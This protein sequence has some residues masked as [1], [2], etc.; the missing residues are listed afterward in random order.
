MTQ[1]KAQESLEGAGSGSEVPPTQRVPEEIPP[2]QRIETRVVPTNQLRSGTASQ[3]VSFSEGELKTFRGYEVK[4]PLG[5]GGGESRT[6]LVEKEG[7]SYL[8]K[9]Y[10]PKARPDREVFRRLREEEGPAARYFPKIYEHGEEVVGRERR[11]FEIAEYLSE[12]SLREFCQTLPR[13]IEKRASVLREIVQQ[14]AEALHALHKRDIIHRDLKPSNILLRSRAPLELVL[15]DFGIARTLRDQATKHQTTRFKGTLAYC[16]PEEFSGLFGKGVDWWHLGIIAYEVLL[17]RNPF[18]GAS[19]PVINNQITTKD[20]P[21]PAEIQGRER[22]L[23]LGL[24]TRDPEK[25]WGYKEVMDWL[26]GESP[27]I[28][29]PDKESPTSSAASKTR[30]YTERDWLAAGFTQESHKHWEK[31]GL[32]PREAQSFKEA[33]YSAPTAAK[34]VQA[35]FKNGKT[36]RSWERANFSPEEAS[37]YESFGLSAPDAQQ[38]RQAGFT[39]ELLAAHR[40]DAELIQRLFEMIR[41]NITRRL[42]LK[43]LLIAAEEGLSLQEVENLCRQGLTVEEYVALRKYGF[44]V[45]DQNYFLQG[46]DLELS[47]PL[48]LSRPLVM[49]GGKLVLPRLIA[50][51]LTLTQGAHLQVSAMQVGKKGLTLEGKS[52]LAFEEAE[53]NG[54]L[55]LQESHL[56]GKRL[57]VTGDLTAQQAKVEV[58]ELNA[59]AVTFHNGAELKAEKAQI[60]GP[61]NLQESQLSVKNATIRAPVTA[62]K[63]KITLENIE[64]QGA[65]V[66]GP[67]RLQESHLAGKRLIVTGDLTAQQAKVEV[68][69]LNAQAVTFHNGAELKA[70]KAQI[71]GPVNL[72][73]SQ[74]SVK[75]ATIRAPVTALKA[76]ITLENVEIQG[77]ASKEN[78]T[79]T[80]EIGLKAEESTL[81][82]QQVKIRNFV[83]HGLYLSKS[84]SLSAVRLEI[85]ACGLQYEPYRHPYH[86]TEIRL[87]NIFP[88]IYLQDSQTIEVRELKVKTGGEG[89]LLER[90]VLSLE[91]VE[92]EAHE[93]RGMMVSAGS[94]VMGKTLTLKENKGSA[95]IFIQKAAE[96]VLEGL[97][98]SNFPN[99]GLYAEET[100]SITLKKAKIQSQGKAAIHLTKGAVLEA[101]QLQVQGGA[102]TTPSITLEK[103]A[104]LTLHNCEISGAQKGVGLSMSQAHLTA[105]ET[106]FRGSAGGAIQM[107]SSNLRLEKCKLIGNG[108]GLQID[109]QQSTLHLAETLLHGQKSNAGGLSAKGSQ[110][111]M[112]NCEVSYHKR[113]GIALENTQATLTG[114]HLHD[115][116]L[117]GDNTSHTAQL[118]ASGGSITLTD[119]Q[120]EKGPQGIGLG[121][122][123][124]QAKLK[125][126]QVKEHGY[127]GLWTSGHAIIEIEGCSFLSNGLNGLSSRSRNYS[128]WSQVNIGRD[129]KSV[130]I[131]DTLIEAGKGNGMIIQGGEVTL[132]GANRIHGHVREGIHVLGGKVVVEGAL[133][134][135]NTGTSSGQVYVEGGEVYL[136][137]VE[138]KE[139]A[140]HGIKGGPSS[141]AWKLIVEDSSIHGHEG[142][143][144][145]TESGGEVRLK[146]V[147]LHGNASKADTAQVVIGCKALLQEV[148][149]KD[150]PKG[151]GVLV[152]AS[153]EIVLENCHIHPHPAYEFHG[154]RG[155]G[156]TL[157]N[158]RIGK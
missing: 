138:I 1:R 14:V 40:G 71:S 16:A 49:Q 132:Q 7:Q 94:K 82:L 69:E 155:F 87:S 54:P 30:T 5:K 102:D 100:P 121:L 105:I 47:D 36:C 59:Q 85:L 84:S 86:S 146:R 142:A 51:G 123:N 62:L 144:V 96:V 53:V 27:A 154:E 6:F 55:R 140:N 25:R 80:M 139:G 115:N 117:E 9:L 37:L 150:S 75:N 22:L 52:Q 46:K 141:G 56:A 118:Y 99:T 48:T 42:P 134:S 50:P 111:S 147:H 124:C 108:Q 73:E 20:I 67:L 126:L 110:V 122:T 21:I 60:S 31:L 45:E 120:I 81:N 10:H 12:G 83:K 148:E 44:Q 130:K 66:N 26:R 2:T 70:E 109:A 8:L 79:S 35:G 153:G 116:V 92:I 65:E 95:Q 74:L 145:F 64:I 29:R 38:L 135:Q 24:L 34:W 61:V 104:R 128:Y 13:G 106:T 97:Q 125:N 15:I 143:G 58:E 23:L 77:D 133:L 89:I 151:G 101:S 43:S 136:C 3:G 156:F 93:G 103:Q 78:P 119:S 137:K 33:G 57:I 32:S 113:A 88:Q 72:Q 157:K 90:S 41:G 18:E 127:N 107:N 11:F 149:V 19:D 63:A 68:E 131:V 39:A 129:A 158:T 17:G 98:M 91:E 114:C 4:G 112:T 152:K 28:H 76:K